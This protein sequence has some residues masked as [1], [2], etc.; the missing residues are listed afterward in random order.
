[1]IAQRVENLDV[2]LMRELAE[3]A[4]AKMGSGIVV[5]GT[6]LEGKAMLIATVSEDLRDQYHAGTVIK[7]IA[8]LVG[9]S[10]GGRK[11][12]AQAGGKEPEKLDQ[13]LQAVYN[14]V[15]ELQGKPH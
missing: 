6:V 4:Q 8:Q 13:A 10:G 7:R 15:E 5:L 12:F 2:N 9:G 14:I 3:A 11:D 1:M